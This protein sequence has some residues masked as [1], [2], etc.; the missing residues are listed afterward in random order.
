MNTYLLLFVVSTCAS[1]LLTPVV[2]R[3][4]RRFGW[5]DQA[6]D[7]RRV[8]RNPVPRLGGVAIF[9]A[10]LLALAALPLIHNLVTQSLRTNSAKLLSVLAPAAIVFLIG[11]YDDFRGTNA[12]IKFT[13]Q[14]L[15]GLLFC[16]LGG[17]IEALSIPLVGSIELHPVLGYGLTLLWTVG[18]SNAFNL[19]DGIDGLATGAA[20]FAALVMLVVSLMLGHPL[21]TVV[22]IAMC[23][24]LIGFLPYNFNPASISLGDSGS[25]FIGFTLAALAVQ[26]TQKA[27][28]AVAVAI[29]LIAFGLP[30]VDTGVSIIRRFIGRRP[31]FQG[32]R[33]HIHHMLLSRG[34]SQRRVA[35]VLYGAC[36]LFGLSALLLVN[37][38]GMR[39]TGLVLCIVG[40]AILLAVGRLRYHEVDEV[41]AGMRRRFGQGRVRVANNI[42][43]R[44]ATSEMSNATTLNEIFRAVEELLELGDFVYAIMRLDHGGN[45]KSDSN[46]D[47]QGRAHEKT[48]MVSGTEIHNGSIYWTWQRG[49]IE[50]DKIVGSGRFWTLR[51]PL[52]T[53]NCEWGYLNLYREF[54]GEALLL[55]I[56][57]LCDLF[58][59]ETAKAVERVLSADWGANGS[60]FAQGA[61]SSASETK[62]KGGKSGGYWP[63]F[64]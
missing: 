19:I 14:G 39:T 64:D 10:I 33:E 38:P 49:N 34:W 60:Q 22:A 5:L 3:I 2:S 11:V 42:R 12:P 62:S 25:L 47:G 30:V 13:A 1:L 29:P 9:A 43:A 59:S 7:G 32:D 8:H 54:G 58:Q 57:Y 53:R 46:G 4:S 18:I 31:L 15:A 26:G 51:L 21:I 63:P 17:R 24:S 45:G 20:L 28:T 35:L 44:R 48:P 37:D 6:R 61:P 52:S 16:A 27:S 50:A 36:A 23:G 55:D 41:K 56:N 40:V